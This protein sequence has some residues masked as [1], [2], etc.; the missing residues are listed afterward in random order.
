MH[1]FDASHTLCM[2]NLVHG[3]PVAC[4]F[5]FLFFPRL[6]IWLFDES[7]RNC[8]WADGSVKA[9]IKEAVEPPSSFNQKNLKIKKC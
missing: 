8:L 4:K 5:V 9:K 1:A 3:K 7:F 2:V 6:P